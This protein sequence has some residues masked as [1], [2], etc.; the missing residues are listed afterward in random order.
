M[1]RQMADCR[2][3]ESD[4]NCSLTIIGEEDEV[5]ETAA[6]HAAS[7]H[8]HQDTPELRVQLRALLEPEDSYVPGTRA[9]EAFPA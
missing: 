5:I 2:R 9:T 6:A 7:V 1:A 3:F 8:G 4:S